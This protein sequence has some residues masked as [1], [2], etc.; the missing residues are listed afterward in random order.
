MKKI[1]FI[2]F[3]VLSMCPKVFCQDNFI[4]MTL[5]SKLDETSVGLRYIKIIDNNII[6]LEAN[7]LYD[8]SIEQN[9]DLDIYKHNGEAYYLILG[10]KIKNISLNGEIGYSKKNNKNIVGSITT[11]DNIDYGGSLGY[12]LNEDKLYVALG[13]SKFK[14]TFLNISVG[15]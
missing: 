9:L 8:S 10:R 6:G 12:F 15:F 7:I 13:Y 11:E 4:G 5:G 3:L 14:G 1:L 2:V